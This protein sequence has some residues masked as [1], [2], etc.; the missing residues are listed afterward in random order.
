MVEM[1]IEIP[2]SLMDGRWLCIQASY[3]N[4]LCKTWIN[5]TPVETWRN[6]FKWLGARKVDRLKGDAPTERNG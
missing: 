5:N 2:E 6:Y 1:G 4:G 3:H